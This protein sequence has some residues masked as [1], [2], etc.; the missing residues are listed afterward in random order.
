M[1]SSTPF[2]LLVI[3]MVII[4]HSSSSISLTPMQVHCFS[5]ITFL[6]ALLYMYIMQ[7]LF[8]Y[9]LQLI[10]ANSPR[11]S[12]N[13]SLNVH[14]FYFNAR[15]TEPNI[16]HNNTMLCK[17][18]HIEVMGLDSFFNYSLQNRTTQLIITITTLCGVQSYQS[19]IFFFNPHRASS[20]LRS[21]IK[22]MDLS[23]FNCV[24]TPEQLHHIVSK[25]WIFF[26]NCMPTAEKSQ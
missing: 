1:N 26:S 23:L 19:C 22:I 12:S 7:C 20:P 2:S 4:D 3:Q 9:V 15:T 10:I 17:C 13:L 18:S 8:V 6:P 14:T 11:P 16:Y 5:A 24:P 25:L 21:H